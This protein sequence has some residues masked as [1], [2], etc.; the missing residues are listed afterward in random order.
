M[1]EQITLTVAQPKPSQT[2]VK[3][4]RFTIDVIAKSISVQWLGN[5]NEPGI[6]TYPTPA[7]LNPLSVLQPSGAALITALNSAN[8][9]ANS[10][11]KRILTQLLT[12]GYVAAGAI[13]G[14]PD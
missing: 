11:V 9:T 13:A 12:D 14:S 6:A 7:V 4:E 1:P 2:L 5:N 10:L 3:L 8:L